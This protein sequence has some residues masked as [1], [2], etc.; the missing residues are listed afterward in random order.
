ML[1]GG[2]ASDVV[3]YMGAMASMFYNR[4]A[5]GTY[6]GNIYTA[7]TRAFQ[8]DQNFLQPTLLPPLTPM[9]RDMDATGFSQNL[10]P[11]K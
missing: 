7:P 3:N 6:K 11:G 8:F 9:F 2:P 1:E 4:Q 10:Q 5:V